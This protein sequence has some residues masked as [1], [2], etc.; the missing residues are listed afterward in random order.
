MF[1]SHYE[2]F[3]II[4]IYTKVVELACSKRKISDTYTF[5]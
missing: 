4:A 1:G 3:V 2:L 5:L